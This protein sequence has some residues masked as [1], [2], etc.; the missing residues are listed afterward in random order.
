[1]REGSIHEAETQN[2]Y[3]VPRTM[4]MT[5]FADLPLA[6]R[7]ELHEGY[8]IATS[9]AMLGQLQPAIGAMFERVAGAYA[10]FA[11]C[12]SPISR[13]IGLGVNGPVSAAEVAQVEE[14]YR[15]RQAQAQIALC[16]LADASL[17]QLLNERGYR[18]GE[19]DNVWVQRL[20]AAGEANGVSADGVIVREAE[21]GDADAWIHAVSGGFAGKEELQAA[22]LEI[23]TVFF[24][25]P[26]TRCFLSLVDGRP[27]GGGA[28]FIHDNVAAFFSGSTL[29]VA[30]GRGAQ[31]ALLQVR[32]RAAREAGCDLALIKTAPGNT[33]QRNVQRA[34]FQLAYTK[35][36]M[37]REWN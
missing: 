27:A 32:L 31:T 30:R 6:R 8:G 12:D 29:P 3:E 2:P 28:M 34:G 1:M 13:A 16:P 14:F 33:S 26:Q 35:V 7:L 9:M 11:G 20:D 22:E 21:A 15:S 4:T 17:K 19:F 5:L 36:M 10:I 25:E 18:V 24:R 23:A 37:I